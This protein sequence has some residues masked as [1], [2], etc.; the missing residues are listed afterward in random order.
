MEVLHGYL[1]Y[2]PTL[3]NSPKAVATTKKGNV[4]FEEADLASIMLTALSLTWQN[5]YNLTHSTVPESPRALL[6]DV[7]NI[8]RVMLERYGEKQRSKDR[9]ATTHLKLDE[10]NGFNLLSTTTRPIKVTKLA[11]NDP[12]GLRDHKIDKI[13][14]NTGK[15]T[16]LVAV[17]TVS[18]KKIKVAQR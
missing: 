13:H 18:C 16:A 6:A 5:Q 9:A 3:K 4:L 8:E 11:H 1:G 17:M 2:L 14:E 10:T 7:E 12:E 15:V